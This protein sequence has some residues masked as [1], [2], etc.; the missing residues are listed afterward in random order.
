MKNAPNLKNFLQTNENQQFHVNTKKE[1][2]TCY[3]LSIEDP[4]LSLASSSIM[5]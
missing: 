5:L 2:P 4:F 3:S 1:V